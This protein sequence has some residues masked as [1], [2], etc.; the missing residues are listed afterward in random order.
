MAILKLILFGAPGAGKGTLAGQIKKVLPNIVHIST[1]DLFRENMKNQT[2]IG[3]KAKEFIDAGKLVPDEVVIGMVKDRL[4]QG[5][6]K[7]WGFM[8]DGFP[9][10]MEQAEALSKVTGIDKVL[11]L[12]I[13]KKELKDR[14][15]GRRSCTKCGKIYNVFNPDLKPK[16]EGICDACG[17]KLMQRSDDNEET[18][19]KRMKTYEEQSVPCIK[20]YTDKKVVKTV[21]S[22]KTM[23]MTEKD[24]KKLLGL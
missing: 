9:R 17:E 22:T 15:L 2:P 10:T 8:L 5:D 6:V 23:Q 13:S 21:D 4:N 7:Q 1:G 19:E 12:E 11:V 24:I 14:I 20:Y 18:F 3:K 16:K